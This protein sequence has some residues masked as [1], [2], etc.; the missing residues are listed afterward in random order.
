[1]QFDT[2]KDLDGNNAL[3]T[4]S[5]RDSD[6][7]NSLTIWRNHLYQLKQTYLFLKGKF[8]INAEVDDA[9]RSSWANLFCREKRIVEWLIV[10][11][12]ICIQRLNYEEMH[13]QLW[14]RFNPLI[15]SR[16]QHTRQIIEKRVPSLHLHAWF[17][18]KN[19]E[20]LNFW[21]LG[22]HWY[23]YRLNIKLK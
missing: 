9:K 4:I 11:V 12:D 15:L 23:R 2:R 5:W 16:V 18:K 20:V 8:K 21:K 10:L 19:E 13:L 22:G 17:W 1:M 3:E 7:Y 6:D 14:W